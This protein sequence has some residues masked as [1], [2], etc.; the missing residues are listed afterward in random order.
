MGKSFTVD[1]DALNNASKE[2]AEISAN[3]TRIST[4]LMDKASTM[5]AAWDADDNLAFV[6]QIT[7]FCDDMKNMASKLQN[8]SEIIAQQSKNYSTHKEDNITQVRKMAN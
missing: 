7:G 8:A 4:Q 6:S 3:Y 5:G 2:L 1:D